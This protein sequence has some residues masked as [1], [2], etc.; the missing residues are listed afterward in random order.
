MA[1]KLCELNKKNGQSEGTGLEIPDGQALYVN[2]AG[3]MFAVPTTLGYGQAI[4]IPGDVVKYVRATGD[5]AGSMRVSF[6]DGD[7]FTVQQLSANVTTDI[8]GHDYVF[9]NCIFINTTLTFTLA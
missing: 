2:V 5:S 1:E 7:T 4:V 3:A 8:S 6:L 9:A